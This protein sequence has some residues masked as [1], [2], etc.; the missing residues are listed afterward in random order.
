MDLLIIV[1]HGTY[2]PGGRLNDDGRRQMS[3]IAEKLETLV[4]NKRIIVLSSTADRAFEGAKIISGALSAP[5]EK[6]KILWS[7]SCHPENF[8]GLLEMIRTRQN[9]A[10]CFILITHLEYVTNFPRYFAKQEWG[11]EVPYMN[12]SKGEAVVLHHA[13]QNYTRI[14]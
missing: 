6:H 1:R 14:A 5:L 9:E 4:T 13:Q 2:G 12:V 3:D 11:V 10:D 8:P 7:E